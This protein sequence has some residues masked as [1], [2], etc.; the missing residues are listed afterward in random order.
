MSKS[1]FN[2]LITGGAG[3]IGNRL[4]Q[5]LLDE[6]HSVVILDD[7]SIGTNH[8]CHKRA[9]YI[10]ADVSQGLEGLDGPEG[11]DKYGPFDLIFHLAALSRIQPS[12]DDPG[13]TFMVNTVG[14]ER[15]CEYARQHGKIPIVYSGSSS[16]WHD[17]YQSPYATY[18][19]LGEEVC[20]MYR[21]TYDM[22]IEIAR[23]YNVYGP[24]EIM[25]GDWAAVIGIW[26]KQIKDGKP[27][28]V[29]GDG[30]QKRDFTHVDH[31]VDGLLCIGDYAVDSGMVTEDQGPDA[32]E[33]GT[34][35]NYSILEV[36]QMFQEHTQ[37]EI[38]HLPD[39]KGNY[40][41]TLRERDDAL[42]KLGWEP[43]DCLRDY[44]RSLYI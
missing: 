5:R 11:L 1:E 15:V 9:H 39:Q 40:R 24:G 43:S 28:T 21:K 30:L 25:D 12:F 35:V 34:G 3:F 38:V 23:F 4:A 7:Y 17:P 6:G 22:N 18:K 44:I 32:W 37:C 36:A 14:T 16:K 31:I 41:V 26:R 29:V 13:R 10:E 27:I 8:I 2:V 42:T 33:L 19:Y 20:K